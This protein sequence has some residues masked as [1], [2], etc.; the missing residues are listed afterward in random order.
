MIS[1]NIVDFQ[2]GPGARCVNITHCFK[3][4]CPIK[5]EPRIIN[6]RDTVAVG[7][8]EDQQRQKGHPQTE[9]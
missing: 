6:E 5:H 4:E 7:Q 1:F 8:A 2:L 9:R 3:P